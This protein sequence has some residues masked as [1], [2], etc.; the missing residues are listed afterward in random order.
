M[1]FQNIDGF[2]GVIIASGKATYIQLRDEY[3]L[4]EAFKIW[5]VI[6]VTNYNQHLANEYYKKK[7]K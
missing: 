7:N 2:I 6:A 4:E 3:T 1:D 5:E